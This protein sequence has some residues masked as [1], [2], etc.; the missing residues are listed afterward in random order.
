MND[1]TSKQNIGELI[2]DCVKA[3]P[4]LSKEC[5]QGL[6]VELKESLEVLLKSVMNTSINSN[7]SII[8]R[9]KI[10]LVTFS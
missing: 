5:I 1:S 9:D 7:E 10:E 4:Q 8:T 2:L 3:C 6:P